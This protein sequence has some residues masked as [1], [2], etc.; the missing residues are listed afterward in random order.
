MT[1]SLWSNTEQVSRSID[2]ELDCED[3]TEK[4]FAE[5]IIKEFVW[6]FNKHYPTSDDADRETEIE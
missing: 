1:V 4:E 5:T 3:A 2:I 6:A